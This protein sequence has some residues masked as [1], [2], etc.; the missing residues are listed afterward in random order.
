MDAGAEQT[1]ILLV[2]DRPANLIALQAILDRKDY[3]LVPAGSGRQALELLPGVDFAVILLDV[4]MPEMDGFAT[5]SAIKKQLEYRD[6]PIIFITAVAEDLGWAYR[7]YDVG[8]I[9]FLEKPL[10][11]HVVRA[12]V[13]FFVEL[14]RQRRQLE[15]Q[16]RKLRE[17]ERALQ[18]MRFRNL[19]DAIPHIVWVATPS[20]EL[21]YVS[22]RWQTWTGRPT[23]AALGR[24]WMDAVPAAELARVRDTWN[25]CVAAGEAFEFELQLADHQGATRWQAMRGLPERDGNGRLTRWLGTLTDVEEQRRLRDDLAASVTMRDEFI[26]VAAHELRT[27]LSALKL[28]IG[29]MERRPA[30]S[31]ED[32]QRNVRL[33]SR[34]IDRLAELVERLLDVSRLQSGRMD[35]QLEPIDLAQVARDAVERMSDEAAKAG[36]ALDVRIPPTVPGLWDRVRMEQVLVNLLSNACKYGANR[37]VRLEVEADDATARIVVHDEGIGIPGEAMNRIFGRFERAVSARNYGGLGLGLYL[38]AQ[39]VE[40]HGGTVRAES[41]PERGA[42][43]VVELPRRVIAAARSDMA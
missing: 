6:I 34:Q 35:L 4:A 3:H 22:R 30:A 20:G 36:C 40:A 41:R 15:R 21:E 26:Q 10:D 27:P 37:P 17:Q 14:H 25:T 33:V 13:S 32:S 12:K 23:A 31:P 39:I 29:S 18:E 43:F 5:A 42:I 11:P 16:Q 1:S 8:A 24:R 28:R 7:A 9:D 19:A 38:V 2:D